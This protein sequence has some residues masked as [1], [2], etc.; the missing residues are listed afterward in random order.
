VPAGADWILADMLGEEPI[1]EEAWRIVQPDLRDLISEPAGI[2]QGSLDAIARLTEG[3]ILGGFAMQAAKS[4]RAASGAE[5]QFSHLWDMQHHTFEGVA[6]S[7]GFKVGIGTLAATALYEFLLQY[8]I[9]NLD[10]EKC[11]HAWLG[12]QSDE[13]WI[14]EKLR[15]NRLVEKARD[16]MRAKRMTGSALTTQLDRLKRDWDNVQARL[17]GQLLPFKELEA[18]L[19]AAGAPTQ[20][21]E[22]GI[23]RERLRASYW[24]ATLIRRRFTV[25]D[26]AARTGLLDSAL[27]TIFGKGGQWP[28]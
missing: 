22:I 12:Q 6:P 20:P 11:C 13:A 25:L 23:S 2:R 27:E 8:P 28:I 17:K 9:Q 1:H 24:Q 26:L 21:E 5:H 16:E 4:S 15:E 7:H 14:A 19:Q 3:L 10:V 18:R